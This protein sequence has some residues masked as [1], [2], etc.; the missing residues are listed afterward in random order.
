MIETQ[1]I[2]LEES[3]DMESS[4]F[5]AMII[6]KHLAAHEGSQVSEDDLEVVLRWAKSTC[7]DAILLSML[8][9]GEIL[10]RLNNGEVEFQL[11]RTV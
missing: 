9:E 4:E 10:I 7:T 6:L 11:V 8:L 5:E 2:T 3:L 1:K